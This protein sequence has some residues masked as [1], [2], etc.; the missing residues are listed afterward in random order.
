MIEWSRQ[1]QTQ[2]AQWRSEAG[3]P[4]PRRVVTADD[5][6]SWSLSSVIEVIRDSLATFT[7]A[8][9]YPATI[10]AQIAAGTPWW[11]VEGNNKRRARLNCIHH[12]L[13]QVPYK[14]VEHQ[15]IVLPKREH[16]P[17]YARTPVAPELYVPAVY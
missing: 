3:A 4:A 11:V 13:Q 6:A 12:L 5:E 2:Q 17:D 16:K 1:G 7:T 8:E 14:D 9:K 15:P 10:A